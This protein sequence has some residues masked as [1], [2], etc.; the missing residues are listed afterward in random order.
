MAYNE[1][2][3]AQMEIL[4]IY[5]NVFCRTDIAP[6]IIT[7]YQNYIPTFNTHSWSV[8][9]KEA[10][11]VYL[12]A[13]ESELGQ[14]LEKFFLEHVEPTRLYMYCGSLDHAQILFNEIFKTSKKWLKIRTLTVGIISLG[15]LLFFF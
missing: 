5:V 6:E 10:N 8:G 11:F 13:F 12:N 15:L 1:K 9:N 4:G 2:L 14:A 7:K 3:S